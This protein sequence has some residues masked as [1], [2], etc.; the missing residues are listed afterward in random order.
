MFSPGR[1]LLA[2]AA[3]CLAVVLMPSPAASQDSFNP[4][5]DMAVNNPEAL[6]SPT[7]VSEVVGA[8][9]LD[10]AISLPEGLEI[11]VDEDASLITYKGSFELS[12]GELETYLSFVAKAPLEKTDG[13]ADNTF[14]ILK[15]LGKATSLEASL[16]LSA[17]TGLRPPPSIRSPQVQA[18]CTKVAQ[19][20]AANA[21]LVPAD[22]PRPVCDGNTPYLDS[23]LVKAYARDKY[24]SW[25]ELSAKPTAALW[26]GGV[27]GAVGSEKFDYRDPA[28]LAELSNTE[29][30][31]SVGGYLSYMRLSWK[32]LFTL[33]GE[34]KRIYK[35]PDPTIRCRNPADTTTCLEAPFGAPVAEDLDIV[36]FEM[37]RRMGDFAIAVSGNYDVGK[38]RMV[39]DVPV[40]FVSDNA[41]GLN[42]GVRAT[43]DSETHET[44]VG[45]FVNKAF[46]FFCGPL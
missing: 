26:L 30:P 44:K 27:S 38:D 40:Y 29:S 8:A 15:G 20:F 46:C 4:V 37:R 31:W 9:L 7:G 12:S 43:W 14:A 39:V 28:T 17:L 41:G 36:A 33:R 32:T 25:L 5:L 11:N 24:Q 3:M 16:N 23:T 45:V 10:S 6:N 1:G 13:D 34:H 42:G 18:I 2:S 22:H 19:G 35:L 21:A